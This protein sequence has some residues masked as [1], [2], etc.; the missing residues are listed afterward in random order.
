MDGLK[1]AADSSAYSPEKSAPMR[2]CRARESGRCVKM[3]GRTFSKCASRQRLDVEV[4][5]VELPA[6]GLE[7]ARDLLLGQGERAAEDVGDALGVA[8]NER[9]DDDARAVGRE[10]HLM[11]AEADGAHATG[12]QRPAIRCS[13]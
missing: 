9:A 12:V 3:C 7:L 1:S 6:H 4:P 13:A 5:R 10:R 11:A 2:S 8:G